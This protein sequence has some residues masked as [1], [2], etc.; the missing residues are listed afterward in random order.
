MLFA[1][2]ASEVE[3]FVGKILNKMLQ[4]YQRSASNFRLD[5]IPTF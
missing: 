2:L 1:L 5:Q 3:W 4:D